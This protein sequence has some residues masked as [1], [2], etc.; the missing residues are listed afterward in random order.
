M[1]MR[2]GNRGMRTLWAALVLG[3][4]AGCGSDGPKKGPDGKPVWE[5]TL[6]VDGTETKLPVKLI[7]VYLYDDDVTPESYQFE[8]EGTLLL[9]SFPKGVS[10]GYGEEWNVL[11]GKEIAI[12]TTGGDPHAPGATSSLTLPG[13]GK[14]TVTGGSWKVEKYTGEFAGTDGDRTLHGTITII[15]KTSGGETKTYTGTFVVQC[16]SWG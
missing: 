1:K 9:G 5:V 12:S 8:G 3:F 14:L 11:I 2:L 13:A 10:V 6:D 15:A 7:N 4:L 16:I